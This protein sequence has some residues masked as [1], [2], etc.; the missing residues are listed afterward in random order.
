MNN[1]KTFMDFIWPFSYI[2]FSILNR[3]R[4]EEEDVNYTWYPYILSPDTPLN[5][6]ELDSSFDNDKKKAVL[7]RL[8]S[9]GSE[10]DL[11]FNN[12]NLTFNSNRAHKAVLYARDQ[13]KFYEFA[14]E[15]FDCVF[16]HDENIGDKEIIDKIAI[17]LQLDV[18]H[19]N[20]AIDGGFYDGEIE[21]AK[22]ASRNYNITSVPTF[23]VDDTRKVTDLKEYKCFKEDLMKK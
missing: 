6:R 5:G 11:E 21:Q 10:Y 22:Q 4:K 15:V 3:L 20:E 9:L 1:I 17:S 19:M 2:G 13:G 18:K 23:I 12:G 16:K 8:N 14:K 7:K